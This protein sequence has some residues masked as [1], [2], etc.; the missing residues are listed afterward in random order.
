MV[1]ERRSAQQAH[2]RF[3]MARA[4]RGSDLRPLGEEIMEAVGDDLADS[5][6][7][8]GVG[9]GVGVRLGVGV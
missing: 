3:A 4:S 2:S 5:R 9:L 6:L 7:P 1:A 8:V